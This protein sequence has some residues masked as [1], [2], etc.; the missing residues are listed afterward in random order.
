[1]GSLLLTLQFYENKIKDVGIFVN[2]L[3]EK[4][5]NDDLI[6]YLFIRAVTQRILIK[7]FYYESKKV[8]YFLDCK[9]NVNKV[10]RIL[11]TIYGEKDK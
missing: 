5:E 3:S 2:F 11:K 8:E 7:E 4:Y 1:M 10:H 6:Y 9:L